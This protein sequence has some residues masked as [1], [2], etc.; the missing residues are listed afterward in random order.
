M[1]LVPIIMPTMAIAFV[2]CCSRVASAIIAEIAA[3]IAPAP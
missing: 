3:E 1:K 2:R